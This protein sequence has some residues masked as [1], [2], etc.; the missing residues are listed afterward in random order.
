[1]LRRYMKRAGIKKI[2]RV[3]NELVGVK[4]ARPACLKNINLD[5][6]TI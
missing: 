2:R 6:V 4:K 1:M 5:G 3:G